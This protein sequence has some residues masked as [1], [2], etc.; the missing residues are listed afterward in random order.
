MQHSECCAA[1]W[2]RAADRPVWYAVLYAEACKCGECTA[3]V[4]QRLSAGSL[5]EL[6][7]ACT[8]YTS[9]STSH[10]CCPVYP[11]HAAVCCCCTKLTALLVCTYLVEPTTMVDATPARECCAGMGTLMG[12][13]LSA[14]PCTNLQVQPKMQ[15]FLIV[16]LQEL[17]AQG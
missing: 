11:A 5:P 1:T 8:S 13:E 16:V 14:G 2:L 17:Q 7:I 4:E 12:R 6:H 15:Q 9:V 10:P 3:A